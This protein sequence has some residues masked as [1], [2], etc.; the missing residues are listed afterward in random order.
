MPERLK[1]KRTYPE[2]GCR[3]IRAH[4]GRALC[5]PPP[6]T[7]APPLRQNRFKSTTPAAERSGYG[8]FYKEI[9]FAAGFTI[10]IPGALRQFNRPK[11]GVLNPVAN[12]PYPNPW[13]KNRPTPLANQTYYARMIFLTANGVHGGS[14]KKE[15]EYD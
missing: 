7:D 8:W 15:H 11:G 1:K 9:Y 3:V 2:P 10:G 13:K 4:T 14:S 12:K 6:R 5:R